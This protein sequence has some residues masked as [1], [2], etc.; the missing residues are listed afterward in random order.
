MFEPEKFIE[1]QV[2]EVK[3]TIGDEKTVIATSG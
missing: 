2:D 1:K 3:A